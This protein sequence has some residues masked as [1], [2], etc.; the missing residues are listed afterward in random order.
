VACG[1][2]CDRDALNTDELKTLVGRT[3]HF[4]TQLDSLANAF[5]DLVEG[6]R[7]RVTPGKLRDWRDVVTF[8]VALYDNIVLAWQWIVPGPYLTLF[9]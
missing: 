4:E 3:F 6:S 8:L 7:L 1:S 5:R 2:C 9:G